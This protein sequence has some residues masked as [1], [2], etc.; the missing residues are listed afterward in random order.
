M[1]S[2][3]PDALAA[4]RKYD[5]NKSGGITVEELRALLA[6]MGLLEG[7]APQEAAAWVVAQFAM[8]GAAW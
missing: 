7:L 2:V 5:R 1:S 8:A 6:D 4:F 3:P